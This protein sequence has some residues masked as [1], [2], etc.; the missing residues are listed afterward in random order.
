MSLCL[1]LENKYA[2]AWEL[3]KH[4][5]LCVQNQERERHLQKWILSVHRYL[6]SRTQAGLAGLGLS[7]TLHVHSF[8]FH[9]HLADVN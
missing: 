7:L 4:L 8:K 9:M 1:S 3:S 5:Q 2:E 6:I